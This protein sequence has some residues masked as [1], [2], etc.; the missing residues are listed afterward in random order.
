[1]PENNPPKLR[2]IVIADQY[3]QDRAT[4]KHIISGTFAN[5][6]AKT[7]PAAVNCGIYIAIEADAFPIKVDLY[8]RQ[9]ESKKEKNIAYW[10][11]AVTE[12]GFYESIEMGLQ[13]SV[14]FDASGWFDFV[15]KVGEVELGTRALY[16]KNASK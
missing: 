1:M 10:D 14:P 15:V 13:L 9:R 8:L 7:F 4:G 6:T 2:A 12:P 3:F 5:F 16:V 11:I